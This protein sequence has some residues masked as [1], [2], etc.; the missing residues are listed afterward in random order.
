MP[1]VEALAAQEKSTVILLEV[2]EPASAGFTPS[3]SMMVTPPPQELELYWK[4]LKAA[5]EGAADY[6]EG[7]AKEL[8]KKGIATERVI[9]RGDPVNTVVNTAKEKNV[10]LIAMTS[11]GRSGLERVFY[12]SVTSGVLHK[13]DRPLLLVR[14]DS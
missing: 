10:D 14:A 2:I 12:G 5:E 11:H 1:H 4:S 3:V 13:I 7:K 6:L 9:Q 8:E